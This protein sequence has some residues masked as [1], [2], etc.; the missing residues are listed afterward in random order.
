M[1][2]VVGAFPVCLLVMVLVSNAQSP[3]SSAAIEKTSAHA[4]RSVNW[5]EGFWQTRAVVR[6]NRREFD[7]CRFRIVETSRNPNNEPPSVGTSG[8]RLVG[9]TP[10]ALEWQVWVKP[11]GHI[12]DQQR[13]WID[14]TFNV[15]W[16]DPKASDDERREAK[17]EDIP[18]IETP[19]VPTPPNS[20]HPLPPSKDWERVIYLRRSCTSGA[21]V[22]TIGVSD[23]S[24]AAA[25][26]AATLYADRRDV[27]RY[28]DNEP[29]NPN[30]SYNGAQVWVYTLKCGPTTP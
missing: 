25:K 24:C 5:N 9:A 2:I 22:D 29:E 27:C 21:S 26:D 15:Y 13:R 14:V 30:D 10:H 4:E 20:S 6:Q 16:I 7:Y 11:Y 19:Y 3:L 8:Y 28:P 18:P 17:C 23:V 1:R 12:F